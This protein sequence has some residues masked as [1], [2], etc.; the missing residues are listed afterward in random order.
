V[1]DISREVIPLA[2][3]P[4]PGETGVRYWLASS[5]RGLTISVAASDEVWV[6]VGCRKVRLKA[7]EAKAI[8]SD[9]IEAGEEATVD[10]N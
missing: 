8:G 2:D 7:A 1:T 10:G 4:I 3:K 5:P 6:T 9:L